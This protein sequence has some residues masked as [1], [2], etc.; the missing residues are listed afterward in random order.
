MLSDVWIGTSLKLS[1]VKLEGCLI[2]LRW[3]DCVACSVQIFKLYL[4]VASF[5][6]FSDGS[7]HVT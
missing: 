7:L 1:H 4:T 2:A 6:L 5:L 3:V